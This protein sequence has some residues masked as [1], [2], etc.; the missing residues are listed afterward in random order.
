MCR[1]LSRSRND[2]SG[3]AG[4]KSSAMV[5][6]LNDDARGPKLV[7]RELSADHALDN[8]QVDK[9][10]TPAFDWHAKQARADRAVRP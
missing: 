6:F 4:V 5:W 1:A 2:N 3:S 7:G 8:T 9:I 10:G